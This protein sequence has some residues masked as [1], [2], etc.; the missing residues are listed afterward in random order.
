MSQHP[1]TRFAVVTDLHLG[2]TREG[3]WHN[4]FLSDHPEET[5]A[6]AVAAINADAPDFTL[7]LGDLAD[8]AS[9][10]QLHLARETL[11]QLTMPW[12]VLRGNHD[13]T[14]DGDREPFNRIFGDRAPTGL[15]PQVMLPRPDGV[16]VAALDAEWGQ[17]NGRWWVNAF[18]EQVDAVRAGVDAAGPALL[19][20]LCHFPFVRQSEYIRTAAPTGKNAGTLTYGERTMAELTGD[21]HRTLFL[22]GHQH[23]HH[24]VESG[25]DEPAWLHVTTASLVEFPAEY[26][27]IEVDGGTLSITTHPAAPATVA[28]NTPTVTWVRGRNE[29]REMRWE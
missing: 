13:V 10:A 28:A 29:D 21:S 2:S 5:A 16:A 26:R 22:A 17:E 18:A 24:I 23:F 7:I 6:A 8:T 19:I 9:D 25:T 12:I 15:V 4:R 20:V 27:L 1:R 3:S 11:D 14:S